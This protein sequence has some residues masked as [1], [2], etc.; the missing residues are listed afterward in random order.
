MPKKAASPP[1]SSDLQNRLHPRFTKDVQGHKRVLSDLTQSWTKARFPHCILLGGPKGIGKA[2]LAYHIAARILGLKPH[3]TNLDLLQPTDQL[4]AHGKKMRSLI[5]AGSH[6]DFFVAERLMDD[7]G[8]YQ[9]DIP[10]ERAREVVNFF[11]RTSLEGTWRVAVIDSVDDL[12]TKG[13]NALLKI[14]EEPPKKCLLILL[15]HN[16][17]M[18]LETLR[19]RSQL[20]SCLPLNDAETKTV[21]QANTIKDED[22]SFLTSVCAGRPGLADQIQELGGLAFYQQFLKLIQ[23]LT[24][25]DFRN[26]GSFLDQFVFKS[27]SLSQDQAYTAFT[28]FLMSWIPDAMGKSLKQQAWGLGEKD[29]QTSKSEAEIAHD[30]FC[31]N[32]KTT[33]DAIATS[34]F[35]AQDL[36]KKSHIFFLD[37]KQTLSCLFYD[38]SGLTPPSRLVS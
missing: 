33:A 37:R 25:H 30:F 35:S 13:A 15:T 29:L 32:P 23:D 10:V 1:E 5:Q 20:F 17:N 3:D 27:K 6:P 2:T 38:L 31:K 12:T 7:Q 34:W 26:L 36:L 21:L 9:K 19:S 28:S 22:L 11:A 18:V 24:V 8:K 14:L 16:P 4:D